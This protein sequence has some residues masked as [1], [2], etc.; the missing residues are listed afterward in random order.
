MGLVPP[1]GLR[2][3]GRVGPG[4]ARKGKKRMAFEPIHLT[5][6]LRGV[7]EANILLFITSVDKNIISDWNITMWTYTILQP[8]QPY[9]LTSQS[10]M[11]L[12]C[13]PLTSIP[14]IRNPVKPIIT[15]NVLYR[16]DWLHLYS[17][18][19]QFMQQLVA[20]LIILLFEERYTFFKM[21]FLQ[22]NHTNNIQQLIHYKK[23]T[24]N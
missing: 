9:P 1:H 19:W 11:G 17:V 21:D 5:P 24:T 12:G 6:N 23:N 18:A 4:R 10:E 14:F 16:S 20:S 3:L 7:V 22:H 13:I 2:H 8:V 15:V